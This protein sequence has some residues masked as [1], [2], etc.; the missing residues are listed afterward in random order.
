MLELDPD[1]PPVLADIA[2]AIYEWARSLGR[3][4]PEAATLAF[5]VVERVRLHV[6]GTAL[7]IGKGVSYEAS[8]QARAIWQNF[9]GRN[10]A[11]L[12]ERYS[13]TERRI[14][15]IID[16]QRAID[17]ARRQGALFA[18]LTEDAA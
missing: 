5:D 3:A 4:H 2:H 16:E 12:A 13:L 9:S 18:P 11:E 7:Y 15:Q 1:Y 6:G 14:R 10:Y 8:Q 17:Q